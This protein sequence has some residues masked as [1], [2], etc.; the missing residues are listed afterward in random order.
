MAAQVWEPAGHPVV[1]AARAAGASLREVGG[2]PLWSLTDDEAVALVGQAG[3]LAAQVQE[4]LLRA[5]AEVD[6][7]E[8]PAGAGAASTRDWLRAAQ[9]MFPA[10]ATATTQLARALDG[11]LAA[12][13]A[14][15]ADG[16]ITAEQAGVIARSVEALPSELGEHVS[17]RAEAI[18]LGLAAELDARQ[19]AILGRRIVEVAAPEAADQAL[20]DALARDEARHR[21]ARELR[22]IDDGSGLT[23]L[24]GQLDAESTAI[25]RAALDPLAVPRP[26]DA[27]GPDRRT[28]GQRTADALI[29]LCRRQLAAGELPDTGGEKPRV[30][31]TCD[32][33]V[34]RARIAAATLDDGTALSAAT[35]RRIACD[36]DIVPAV[37][38]GA[39]QV[40]DLGRT[41]RLFS[42]S[43][44][45]AL[46]LRDGG[47]AF[48]GC[49]RP[50]TW[51]D[52]HHIIYWADGG[53]TSL[54]NGVL[55]CGHHHTVVH[56]G[57]WTIHM[58]ADGFPDFLPPPWIDPRQQPR[59][60]PRHKLRHRLNE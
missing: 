15:L 48:P 24:R 4:L 3:A 20:A 60:N 25:L 34:L 18:L 46:T 39:S 30:V 13:R 42:G 52:A 19:L 55:L 44:R 26:A 21:R 57:E 45:R 56:A 59:R 16:A 53:P 36:A 14:A 40:L 51:C 41:T 49:D 29:E 23:R 28:A 38:G 32:L 33:D 58:A 6:R 43:L 12:I 47:C 9:R 35:A 7:R 50:P 54:D 27:D 8:L 1:V 10:A 17:A 2:V 11:R 5:V 31:L 37:L 22:L